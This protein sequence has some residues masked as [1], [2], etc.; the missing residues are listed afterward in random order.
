[1]DTKESIEKHVLTHEDKF[2]CPEC[3]QIFYSAY[4]FA[5][6]MKK[7]HVND[8]YRCPLCKYTTPR[9]TS[10]AQHINLMHLNKYIHYCKF[11]GKGYHDVLAC[12]EHEDVHEGV[13]PL[14]CIVC[15]KE[16]SYS[17]NLLMHQIRSHTVA[18]L[19]VALANQCEVCRRTFARPNSLENHMK[20]HETK[21]PIQKTHLCDTCGKGFA[22]KNKLI[23]HYRV[24]TGYKPHK[25]SYCEKSFTKKDYLVLHERIHS[26][27]K[28]YFCVFCE[29]RF[30]QDASL[31]IHIR[32]HTGERPYICE[33]CDNGF[34][35]KAALRIHQSNC[36]GC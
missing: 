21:K 22:R 32:T 30:N 10:I 34:V 6:H 33:L 25:C 11:C 35:S 13:H 4:K 17:R 26:G 9:V 29:K 7:F 5:V 27:E 8:L 12:R 20:M 28:P 1:M 18:I 36:T 24:H 23:L 2:E 3:G 16:F 14:A 19:G 15:E 31:R